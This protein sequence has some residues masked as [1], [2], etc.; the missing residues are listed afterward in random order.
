MVS[1]QV[2]LGMR[3][4]VSEKAR[5]RATMTIESTGS[6]HGP[7]AAGRT[8]GAEAGTTDKRQRRGDGREHLMRSA[9]YERQGRADEVLIVGTMP[10]PEPGP[11]E[12]RI[13]VAAS[14]VNPGD[15]KKRRDEFSYGMPFPRVIP[16]S[17]GA[18]VVDR[19]GAGVPPA[20]IG[21]RVWC[22]GAQTYRPY[23]TAAEYCVVPAVQAVPLPDVVSFEQ[24]ACLGIPGITAHRA[25]H[26]GGA[27]AGRS[28]LVQGA[29]GAVGLCAV[30]LAV[31]A[32]ATV[33]GVVR[34]PSDMAVV[35]GAGAQHVL[36]RSDSTTDEVRALT[37]DGVYHIVDVAFGA[38][39]GL[40]SEVLAQ[41][42]SI[43]A[44][45]T[46]VAAPTVPFW[47]LLFKNVRIYL[48]G[49]DD[50]TQAAKVAAATALSHALGDGW[51]GLPI[52]ECLPLHEIVRAH[53]L[54]EQHAPRGKV[55]LII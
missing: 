39:A 26:V 3:T 50:V 22:Y 42:G 7:T 27:L 25:L 38:N 41:G 37:P 18:G 20:R 2:L 16:H 55:V 53:E 28:V 23:G 40:N 1:L 4:I 12:V 36:V 48:V 47:P 43:A 19:A 30:H 49:S 5:T 35:A 34:K 10:D 32:G 11:G 44:F 9:W 15:V 46:D 21:Q 31:R 8:G 6:A 45:A 29:A 54:V 24:G 13:R 52:A 17:D 33:I 51:H 14:G